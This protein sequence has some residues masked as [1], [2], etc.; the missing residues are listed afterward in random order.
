MAQGHVPQACALLN[1]LI[2]IGGS[3]AHQ[4]PFDGP[5][6]A[7]AFLTDD[8]IVSSFVALDQTGDVAGFQVVERGD[9]DPQSG[10]IS[11]FARP[12]D[13]IKG[14]GRALFAETTSAMKDAGIT[15]IIAVIRADNT[16]GLGYYTAMGFKDHAIARGVPLPDG[17]PI[18]RITKIYSV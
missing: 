12:T 9:D 14:V 8:L 5:R 18:D 2:E 16:S 15:R 7:A 17:T 13:P 6:F 3:T 1:D 10:Y 4:T 11:S